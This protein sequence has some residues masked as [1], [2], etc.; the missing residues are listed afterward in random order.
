MG[1]DIVFPLFDTYFYFPLSDYIFFHKK[2][3][4]AV[5]V[6]RGYDVLKKRLRLRAVYPG[7]ERIT[8]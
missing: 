8:L 7:S 3:S 2:E 5:Y 6:T 1:W 4:P